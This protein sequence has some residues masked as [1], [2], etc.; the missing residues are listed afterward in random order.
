MQTFELVEKILE[1]V[2]ENCSS[3]NKAIAVN[4]VR[5]MLLSPKERDTAGEVWARAVLFID[6]HDSRVGNLIYVYY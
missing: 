6:D 4:H 3:E 1:V 5:D 2:E